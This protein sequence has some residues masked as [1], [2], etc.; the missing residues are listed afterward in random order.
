MRRYPFVTEVYV[1]VR[2][3]LPAN[4][5]ACRLRDWM[6]GPTGQAIVEQSG[7]VPVR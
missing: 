5:P 4:H 2:H 3:D 7:Y 6:L 1:I